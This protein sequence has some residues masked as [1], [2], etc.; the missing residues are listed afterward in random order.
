MPDALQEFVKQVARL[1]LFEESAEYN[2][3]V[4]SGMT[5]Q[6]SGDWLASQDDTLES[7][8]RQARTLLRK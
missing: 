1:D 6:C 7:L 4:T 8:I 3:Q 5:P 2:E